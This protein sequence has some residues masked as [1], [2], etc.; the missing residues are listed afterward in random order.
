MSE[1]GYGFVFIDNQEE[2]AYKEVVNYT[3]F[4]ELQL[5]KPFKGNSY[6]VEVA[7]GSSKLIVIRQMDPLGFSIAYQTTT[8]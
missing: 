2:S 8:S 7:G 1:N 6:D 3:K 4:E 5:M